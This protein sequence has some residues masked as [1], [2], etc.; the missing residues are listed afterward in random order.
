MGNFSDRK[1]YRDTPLNRITAASFNGL[2]ATDEEIRQAELRVGTISFSTSNDALTIVAPTPDFGAEGSI[3]EGD[4]ISYINP[5][6]SQPALVGVVDNLT[7]NAGRITGVDLRA[8][9]ANT[10]TGAA[11]TVGGVFI[12]SN[13]TFWVTIATNLILTGSQ[14]QIPNLTGLMLTG[15]INNNPIYVA[16]TQFSD[17]GNV[18]TASTNAGTNITGILVPGTVMRPVT[19][20]GGSA[21]FNTTA[22]FPV[23]V[24]FSFNPFGFTNQ[25]LLEGTLYNLSCV[26]VLPSVDFP[27]Q[28]PIS[29]GGKYGWL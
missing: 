29:P 6:T 18:N 11:W 13:E 26:Q 16:F 9:A 24:W 17:N 21:W 10:Y 27:A 28:Y 1:F 19:G 4:I 8:N 22:D 14:V 5:I 3:S 23:R 20:S 7:V 25:N 15:G 2:G 12:N